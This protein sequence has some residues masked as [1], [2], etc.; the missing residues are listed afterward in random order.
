V[1]EKIYVAAVTHRF[2][3]KVKAKKTQRS[4]NIAGKK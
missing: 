3:N 2:F 1:R 4:L